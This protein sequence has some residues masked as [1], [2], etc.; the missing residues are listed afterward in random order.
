[1]DDDNIKMND[2]YKIK[3]SDYYISLAI[4]EKDAH[5]KSKLSFQKVSYN[6]MMENINKLNSKLEKLIKFRKVKRKNKKPIK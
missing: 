1:M 2:A 5:I 4:K 6:Q 3:V